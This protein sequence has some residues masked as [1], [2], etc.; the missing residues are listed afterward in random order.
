MR[1]TDLKQ[2]DPEA[3]KLRRER[4]RLAA[5]RCREKRKDMMEDLMRKNQD[6]E[7]ALEKTLQEQKTALDEA[8]RKAHRLTQ[9][10]ISLRV[11]VATTWGFEGP[12]PLWS[13]QPL[14]EGTSLISANDAEGLLFPD[15]EAIVTKDEDPLF[16]EWCHER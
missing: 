5:I 7:D 4:N 15:L 3:L 13:D 6:L 9:E 11:Y 16:K 8:N 14:F 1:K 10:L 12:L 2:T